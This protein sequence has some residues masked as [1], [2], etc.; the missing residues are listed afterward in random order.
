MKSTNYSVKGAFSAAFTATARRQLPGALIAAA[1]SAIVSVIYALIY[2]AGYYGYENDVSYGVE[3]WGSAVLFIAAVYCSIS[4][5][6]M[7]NAYFS[8]RAC[9][10]H[11]AMPFKRSH[12]YN[13][14][15]LFGLTA[16]ALLIAVS[17]AVFSAT[18]GILSVSNTEESVIYMIQPAEVLKP[19]LT[20]LASLLA[21]YS[22]CT[23][24]AAVSG[25]WLQYAVLVFVCIFSVPVLLIGIAARI[26]SI[27]GVLVSLFDFASIT[28]VGAAVM[29]LKEPTDGMYIFMSVVA[30]AECLGMYLAGLLSFKRRKAETAES[31]Q[32]GS[33]IKYLLMA[34]FV[35]SGFLYFG[36]SENLL[37]T[38][39]TGVITAF[40]CAAMF[41]AVQVRRK[42]VF[43]KQTGILFG[44][45]TG[46][47]LVL[48]AG[49]YFVNSS[50]YVKY[51][52]KADEVES[53][54]ITEYDVYDSYSSVSL[55]YIMQILNSSTAGTHS[56]TL[57]EPQNIQTVVD[58]HTLAVSDK[59]IRN[60]SANV[61]E[62][63]ND[64]LS[65]GPENAVQQ[66]TTVAVSNPSVAD[67]ITVNE[68]DYFIGDRIDCSLA[69]KLK[70]GRTV[71]RSYAIKSPND[72][73]WHQFIAMFKN[74]E[75]VMQEDAFA[76]DINDVLYVDTMIYQIVTGEEETSVAEQSYVLPAAEWEQIRDVLAGD[77]TKEEDDVF[78]YGSATGA[79]LTVYC[80][81]PEL[82][83]EQ[84]AQLRAMT[85]KERY[86]YVSQ[87]DL[88]RLNYVEQY[89]VYPAEEYGVYITVQDENTMNL[90]QSPET[91]DSAILTLDLT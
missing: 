86:D 38:I 26:N 43:T 51:V 90:L 67:G 60:T 64:L 84:K 19:L 23:M 52:P 83:E 44:A 80:I 6:V 79:V 47:C 34:L 76:V 10:Y 35:A 25:K 85:P 46:I 81:N 18:V 53:V 78:Y 14:S 3:M 56:A 66:A 69:Y 63:A 54:T 49:I 29:L 20:L 24:C 62:N 59:V 48:T 22:A 91:R 21:G 11:F 42:K 9:D 73:V 16:I 17:V 57:T 77:R 7:F 58:F 68:E 55:D 75:A 39:V 27:W 87:A 82:S 5:G 71:Y 8:R 89:G 61:A 33:F 72:A 41:S 50:S 88:D 40:A 13:A 1:V 36:A 2:C 28:P 45:V 65:A 37:V 70:D 74:K 4:V 30:L 15:Y 31:G 32:G 12:L